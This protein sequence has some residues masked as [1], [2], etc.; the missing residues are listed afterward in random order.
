LLDELLE[1][2]E[3]QR[4]KLFPESPSHLGEKS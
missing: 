2:P 3:G 4:P 1:T